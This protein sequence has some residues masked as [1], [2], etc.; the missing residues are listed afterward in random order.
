MCAHAS[1]SRQGQYPILFNRMKANYI[2]VSNVSIEYCIIS[3]GGGS[4]AGR[5]K[6]EDGKDEE[7]K[8]WKQSR[9][10]SENILKSKGY[11][12]VRIRA[13]SRGKNS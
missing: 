9:V 6:S 8:N 11:N 2:S 13:C 12:T 1:K 4:R 10:K 5:I 7:S 3:G